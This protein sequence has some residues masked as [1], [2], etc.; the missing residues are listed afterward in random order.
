VTELFG[1]GRFPRIRAE[2]RLSERLEETSADARLFRGLGRSYGDASLPRSAD[3]VVVSTRRA[4]RILA[5]DPASGVLRAEAGLSLW[6]LNRIFL[7]RCF[8]TPVSPG[9]QYVTLG[10]MVASD[11]HGKNHHVAGC[12]G[13]H[14]MSLRMRV[15]DGRVLEVT[16]ANEPELFRATLGGMGLTGHL[17]E[18]EVK[19][20]R[21]SSPWVWSRVEPAKDIDDLVQKVREASAELP[22]TAAW[23]DSVSRGA[24]L[25][26]GIVSAGRWA[27]PGEART[28]P[29]SF[30]QRLGVPFELPVGLVR[31][32]TVRIF[33]AG[34]HA[35]QASHRSG[36]VHPQA[37][38][39]PLDGVR[40]W[41]RLYG[42]RGFSQYQCVVPVD[43]AAAVF[44]RILER[45]QQLGGASAVSVVKDCGPE[46]R[47]L[48]SFPMRGMSLSL[49]VPLQGDVT[50]R[51]VDA[52]NEIV[53]D[54]GGRI[55]MTKDALTRREHFEAMEPRLEAFRRVRRKWDPEGRL[56]SAL[57][58][59]LIDEP[60]RAGAHP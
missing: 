21:V 32:W 25:G 2:Q 26:R 36:I 18:V 44:R 11:V 14:V 13:E 5:F 46:G 33:N 39:Y 3:E 50:Q 51:I 48:L 52:M 7:P 40:H 60:A 23:I 4:D 53:I 59:R 55:Y 56:G 38:W 43:D 42:R 35:Y 20:E 30:Q 19:L 9:T 24:K 41:N 27:E 12:F 15:P 17:L 1:W 29:P 47:G 6:E 22:L 49:D 8:F 31:P 54:A 45:F 37:F 10:G 16:E 34:Y 57:S 58:A 28:E